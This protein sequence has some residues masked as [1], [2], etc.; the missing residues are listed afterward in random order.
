MAWVRTTDPHGEPGWASSPPMIATSIRPR[1]EAS[2]VNALRQVSFEN[3]DSNLTQLQLEMIA[4][5]V[6]VTN[7]CRY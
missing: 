5:V 4:T 3:E 7:E 1:T 6:S 2:M